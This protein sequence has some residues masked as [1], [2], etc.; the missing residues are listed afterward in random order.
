MVII[1]SQVHAYE[2]NTPGNAIHHRPSGHHAAP[3]TTR[4]APALGRPAE[5][6][7]PRQAPERG[8]QGERRLHALPGTVSL[9]GHLGP[10]C[11][12]VRRLGFR[13]LPV[14]HR[15]D[16]RLRSRQLR[17]GRRALP[18]D[19]PPERHRTGD[20]DGR[21]LRQGL[22]LVAEER[23]G[24]VRGQVSGWLLIKV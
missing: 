2:A 18:P 1:D 11:P 13:P 5:S 22:W 10:A 8:Y 20:A 3:H 15:L 19:R 6:A 12:R 21:C 24:H 9:P 23:A 16:P 7:G 14:G 17:T 4:P